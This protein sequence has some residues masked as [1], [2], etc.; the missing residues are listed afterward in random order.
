[1]TYAEMP[2]GLLLKRLV[3][4]FWTMYFSMVAITNF[5]DLLGELDILHW[6][7]LNSG[8]FEYLVSVVKVYDVGP[9]LTKL[10]LVGAWLL[11]VTA[12]V[13]FWRGAVLLRALREGTGRG[14]HGARLGNP[15]LDRVRLQHRV[16]RRLHR[17][18]AVPRAADD[19]ARVG[20]GDHA[21]AGPPRAARGVAAVRR[22]IAP[23][24]LTR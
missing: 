1:M 13:L 20:P 9:D 6:T 18:G 17:R 4:L 5:V 2:L 21:R 11:E 14:A 10:L 8:N 16:L 23:P 7:F 15:G 12:S 22:R 24:A 3:L 19:H